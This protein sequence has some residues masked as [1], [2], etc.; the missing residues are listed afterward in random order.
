VARRGPASDPVAS[1]TSWAAA[2]G[3]D[4]RRWEG[5]PAPGAGPVLYLVEPGV[6]PPDATESQDWVRLPLDV[7]DVSARC[8][9]LVASAGSQVPPQLHLDRDGILRVGD[10][11]RALTPM[12]VRVLELL[13]ARPG[14]V[15]PLRS[16]AEAAWPDVAASERPAP[17]G[18]IKRLRER[19][20][21]LPVEV[22]AVWRR[23]IR[24]VGPAA[25]PPER[26]P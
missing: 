16:V 7:D 12:D 18:P 22:R 9:R 23:G 2:R 6:E 19:L 13:L 15:V 1:A 8:A 21:G 14:A 24:L 5:S 17:H 4:V 20:D 10:E 11:I 25:P 26:V 3:I